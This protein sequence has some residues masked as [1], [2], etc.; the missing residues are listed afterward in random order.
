MCTGFLTV[1]SFTEQLMA[2]VELNFRGANPD[3]N[4]QPLK[5]SRSKYHVFVVHDRVK[6]IVVL[7]SRDNSLHSSDHVVGYPFVC[8]TCN[9]Y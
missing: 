2:N 1:F 4:S 7:H 8:N 5:H 9:E 6:H 3:S